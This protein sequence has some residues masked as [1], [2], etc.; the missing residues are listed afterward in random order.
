MASRRV[1][2]PLG[3]KLGETKSRFVSSETLINCF[4]EVDR[5]TGLPNI[6]GGPGLTPF[7][8]LATAGVRGL[9]PFGSVLVAVSGEAVYTVTAAAVATSRGAIPGEHPVVISDNGT[10]CVIV[11]NPTGYVLNSAYALSTISD[12]DFQA[13]SSVDFLDQYMIFTKVGT[14]SFFL[15]ALNDAT[16]YDA[17]DIASAERRPDNLLRV[18]VDNA[19]VL[20]FGEKTVEGQY[21]SGGSDFPFDR[22]QTFVEYGL[23]GT[24]AITRADNTVFWLTDRFTIRSLRGGTAGEVSDD[25]LHAVIQGWTDPGTARGFTIDFRGH[26][27][28][29]FRHPDGCIMLDAKTGAWMKRESYGQSTWRAAC[30]ARI[31]GRTIVGDAT[32]GD[33][34]VIDDDAYDENG[35]A[36]VRFI[37]SRTMGPGG[38]PFTLDGVEVEI[39]P[40]VGLVSGQGS[41][42]KIWLELSRDSGKTF[43]ARLE[44]SI[45]ARGI[46]A[47]RIT[48]GALGQFPPHGGV[49]R[50]GCSDPVSLVVG[51][52]WADITPDRV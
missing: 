18:M 15:S 19:E 12:G 8:T 40:G 3:R 22:T 32:T 21:D 11:A 28:V 2:I 16:S 37:E 49:I 30:A 27:F 26:E 4:I 9:W 38:A 20:L 34:Y 33:L 45:G 17:L 1:P 52:A 36:M 25:A 48:W 31:W 24:H 44:R 14:G 5:E 50:I 39:E 46:T 35:A 23:A 6:Y 7:V 41:D 47:K 51:R 43:G 10:Q 29:T 42:P 13:A